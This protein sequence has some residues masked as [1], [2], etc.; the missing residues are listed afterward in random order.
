MRFFD[1]DPDGTDPEEKAKMVDW[2][3]GA[4]WAF[5]CADSLAEMCTVKLKIAPLNSGFTEDHIS[6]TCRST[7]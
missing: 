4:N 1:S 2:S 5:S 3:R 7:S 6:N